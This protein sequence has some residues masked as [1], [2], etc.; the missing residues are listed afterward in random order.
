[1][2][3]NVLPVIPQLLF[4]ER[5]LI[6]TSSPAVQPAPQPLTDI[7]GHIFNV[8]QLPR[9]VCERFFFCFFF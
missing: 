7:S 4:V 1:M 5:R 3:E 6:R 9:F 8:F 2:V